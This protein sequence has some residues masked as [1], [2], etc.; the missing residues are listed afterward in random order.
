MNGLQSERCSTVRQALQLC[1]ISASSCFSGRSWFQP[2]SPPSGYGAESVRKAT[3]KPGTC[4]VHATYKPPTSQEHGR[5]S[6]VL[7]SCCSCAPLVLR[8]CPPP[9]RGGSTEPVLG[10]D[11]VGSPDIQ[12]RSA[13]PRNPL[14]DAPPPSEDALLLPGPRR[15]GFRLFERGQTMVCIYAAGMMYCGADM[16]TGRVPVSTNSNVN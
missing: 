14:S 3:P 13:S 15:R 1:Q 8:W 7:L 12:T 16:P 9:R 4:E 10:L 2:L 11:S 5:C 6:L